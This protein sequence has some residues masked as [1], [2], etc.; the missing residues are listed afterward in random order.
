MKN[1]MVAIFGRADANRNDDDYIQAYN[2]SKNLS[3]IGCI[4]INGGYGGIMEASS[5]GTFDAHGTSI[6]VLF[7]NDERPENPYLKKKFFVKDL[8]LRQKKLIEKSDFFVAFEP[9]AGTLS[10]V[11]LVFALWKRGEKLDS[12]MLL[13]GE[14]WKRIVTYLISEDVL[15][16][17]YLN[18]LFFCRDSS[19]AFFKIKEFLGG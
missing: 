1:F 16:R 12:P 17:D 5:K 10:E 11:C 7:K 4:I 15:E 19:E 13:V 9:K 18:K 6:G 3:E 8:Y 2:L 14:K